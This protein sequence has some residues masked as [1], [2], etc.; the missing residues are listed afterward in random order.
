M[1]ENIS[2]E[3]MNFDEGMLKKTTLERLTDYSVLKL[4]N[5]PPDAFVNEKR[6]SSRKTVGP[7]RYRD[8]FR[9]KYRPAESPGS[10][11]S[12]FPV[13]VPGVIT[14]NGLHGSDQPSTTFK[15]CHGPVLGSAE[16]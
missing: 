15:N 2:K 6:P 12:G 3:P 8:T 1:S 9:C 13:I 10:I 5:N 4:T 14:L 16:S 7:L 11:G